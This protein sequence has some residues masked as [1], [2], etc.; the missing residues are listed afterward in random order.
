MKRVMLAPCVL[1]L[2][3]AQY[4]AVGR[5]AEAIDLRRGVPDDVFLVVYAKHNPERDYQK[6][7]YEEVWKTVQDTQILD[8]ALK[9][10]TSRLEDEQL[11]HASNVVD[12]LR[13]ATK[14]IDMQAIINC[15]EMVYAQEML[16]TDL[17]PQAPSLPVSQHLV[18]L[19]LTPEAAA[20]TAD[21]VKNLFELVKK[22]TNGTID[23]TTSE[24]GDAKLTTLVPPQ[25]PMQPT[26]ATLGDVLILCS[27][28]S[29]LEKSLGMMTSTQ[30]KSKFDDP[31]LVA[32]LKKLP[33]PEDSLVF[34]DGRTQFETLQ[35]IGP[36][37][38]QM[39]GGDP[40]V[41]RA[42]KIV[43]MV[44]KDVSIFDF[45]VTVEYTEGNLDGQRQLW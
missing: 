32:A 4:A 8:K 1:L 28:K 7:Y 23:V 25:G 24:V 5:A 17:G 21:G 30:G 14:P 3:V 13:E 35:K 6:Q 43:D 41:D 18:M 9:I 2:L 11:A 16:M 40:N 10:V 29:L 34:Y 39:G 19:R 22:Y 38:R 15:Q 31:R 12:Q 45:E 26:V 42:A 44:M 20:S 37:I 36:M 27:S 33:T